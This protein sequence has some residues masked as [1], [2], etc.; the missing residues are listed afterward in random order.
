MSI[1]ALRAT[2][3]GTEPGSLPATESSP[4]VSDHEQVRVHLADQF[5]QG[6]N[7]RAF[8]RTLLD[9]VSARGSRLVVRLSEDPVH[10]RVAVQL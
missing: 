3:A 4:D 8:D 5:H 2:S 7:R 1:R 9:L 10:G 6:G